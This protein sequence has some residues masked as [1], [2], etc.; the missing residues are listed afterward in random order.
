MNVERLEMA[1]FRK[2]SGSG[3]VGCVEVAFLTDAAG[4]RDSKDRGGP[5]LAF[6]AG[7]W[8]AFTGTVKAGRFDLG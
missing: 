2:A 3:D 1:G 4:V 6:S 7:E 8:L 5:V